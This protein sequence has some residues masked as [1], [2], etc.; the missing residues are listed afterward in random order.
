MSVSIESRVGHKRHMLAHEIEERGDPSYSS[1][2]EMKRDLHIL[3]GTRDCKN[4]I[5][6]LLKSSH[7]TVEK[8]DESIRKTIRK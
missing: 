2:P 8:S 1:S 5:Y 3:S 7:N 4:I 6:T